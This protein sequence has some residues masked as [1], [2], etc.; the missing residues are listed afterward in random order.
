MS[1]LNFKIILASAVIAMG[2]AQIASA[3]ISDQNPAFEQYRA[4]QTTTPRRVVKKEVK[5]IS[6]WVESSALNVRDNPVAGKVVG[7]LSYGQE[8]LAYD[9]YENWIRISTLDTKQKWVN[10]D[11]LSNS[12]L[13]WASYVRPSSTLNA[14]FIPVRIKDR[15]D[16]KKRMFGVRLKKSETDNALITTQLHTKTGIFFQNRFVSC[17]KKKVIGVRLIGE[18]STFLRAQNNVRNSDMDIYATE[19]IEDK[20]ENSTASAIASFACKSEEF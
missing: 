1:K 17:D 6:Y 2:S 19:Q 8:I 10:S 11:F 15:E 5:P 4:S 14:D 16:R 9:Q 13:S 20:A 3:Q 18:G 7:S 12:A